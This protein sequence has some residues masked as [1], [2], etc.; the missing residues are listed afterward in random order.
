MAT[1]A[2]HVIAPIVAPN[3]PTLAPP[4]PPPA[5]DMVWI[6][7]GEFSMGSNHHYP[8]ER[9]VHR[10]H[11]DGFW[12]DRSPVTNDRFAAFAAATHHTTFA[13]L[14]PNPADY[15]GALPEMLHPGSLV[16]VRPSGHINL[17]DISNWWQFK[18]G[19][20]WRHPQGPQS[21]LTGLGDHPVVHVTYADAEAFAAWEG[22]HLPTE[23]EWEFAARGGLDG[24]TYAWGEDWMPDGR[25]MANTWQGRFPYENTLI[26]AWEG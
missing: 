24:A 1:H 25:A 21:D 14:P 4:G 23:A 9:P 13:E 6:P 10:V 8:E 17:G 2:P 15:P 3:V 16:F 5:H 11:V 7:G 12:I 20:D 26:D 18:L 22:K 19:A